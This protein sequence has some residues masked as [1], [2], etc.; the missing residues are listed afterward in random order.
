MQPVYT[1]TSSII[2]SVLD[3]NDNQPMFLSQ[4]YTA[5]VKEDDS[6]PGDVQKIHLVSRNYC[7]H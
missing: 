1:S 4:G 5:H 3:V 2:V 7:K 6:M